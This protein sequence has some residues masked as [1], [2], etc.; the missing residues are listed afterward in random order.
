M[1]VD[2]SG[3]ELI[4]REGFDGTLYLGIISNA[5]RMDTAVAYLRYLTEPLP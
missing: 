3:S 4:L 1:A 5:P 2:I